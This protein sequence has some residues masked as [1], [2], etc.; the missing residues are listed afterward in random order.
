M[1][2]RE[3]DSTTLFIDSLLGRRR[4]MRRKKKDEEE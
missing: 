1:V 4:R 3:V 2:S